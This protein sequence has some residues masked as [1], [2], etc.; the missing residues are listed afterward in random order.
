M[1]LTFIHT[2]FSNVQTFDED[3]H[4]PHTIRKSKVN[5]TPINSLNVHFYLRTNYT[6]QKMNINFDL[7]AF[8]KYV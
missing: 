8:V 4:G 2:N 3:T 7:N 6:E 1:A 5:D